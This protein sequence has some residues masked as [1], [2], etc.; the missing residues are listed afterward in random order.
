MTEERPGDT[1]IQSFSLPKA[2]VQRL[3]RYCKK[4]MKKKSPVVTVAIE[5]FLNKEEKRD[6]V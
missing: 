1:K 3:K 5:R 2:M 4:K 6:K